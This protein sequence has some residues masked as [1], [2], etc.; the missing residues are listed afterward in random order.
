MMKRDETIHD[1]KVFIGGQWVDASSGETF[2]SQD[3]FTAKTWARIPRCG[4]GRRGS[5]RKGGA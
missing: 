3:P 1:Y 4:G 5:R 2:E